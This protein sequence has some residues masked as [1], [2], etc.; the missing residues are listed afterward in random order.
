MGVRSKA[1]INQL[2][3]PALSHAPLTREKA[4]YQLTP[5]KPPADK[6]IT[7]P[8]TESKQ[9]KIVEKVEKGVIK[10][11]I[12]QKRPKTTGN[13]SVVSKPKKVSSQAAG[14][15]VNALPP[16]R[17]NIIERLY[18]QEGLDNPKFS[19]P[20]MVN[21]PVEPDEKKFVFETEFEKYMTQ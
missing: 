11:A 12:K 15:K 19:I 9:K 6:L 3:S 14:V 13:D 7:L 21:P 1:R 20:K 18:H 16:K 4:K 8:K 10:K 5:F 2:M 17:K